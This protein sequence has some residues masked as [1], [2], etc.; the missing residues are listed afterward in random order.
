MKVDLPQPESAAMP[1]T[2]DLSAMD[3]A[4]ELRCA[5]RDEERA[6]P[7]ANAAAEKAATASMVM[8]IK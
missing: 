3:T 2:T 1:M 7:G 8:S 5:T 6:E 4:H